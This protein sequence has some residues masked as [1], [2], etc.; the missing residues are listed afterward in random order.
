[1]NIKQLL[2]VTAICLTSISAL[3]QKTELK[4]YEALKPGEPIYSKNGKWVL[5]MENVSGPKYGQY[6][7]FATNN[8]STARNNGTMSST[9]KTNIGKTRGKAIKLGFE[10]WGLEILE[11]VTKD[12]YTI[13]E[14]LKLGNG[15]VKMIVEND[16]TISFLNAKGEKTFTIK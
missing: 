14:T 15:A 4:L 11:Y 12:T 5:I 9:P 7:T 1:M 13:I 8:F 10:T 2:L 6:S 3:A 16:G